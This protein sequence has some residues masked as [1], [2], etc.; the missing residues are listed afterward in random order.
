M[1]VVRVRAADP[2]EV[3]AV[4]SAL[5]GVARDVDAV[6]VERPDVLAVLPET[7]RTGVDA[8]V[9][10]LG[11][12]LDG[13]VAVAPLLST[14]TF[15]TSGLTTRALLADLDAAPHPP[16]A[17]LGVTSEPAFRV[18]EGGAALVE[19]RTG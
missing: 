3:G 9:R 15:P 8:F 11:A 7:D 10:R 6:W 2:R 12:R 1:S 16:G 19:E 14:T 5:R 17:P 4:E 13:R 18:V